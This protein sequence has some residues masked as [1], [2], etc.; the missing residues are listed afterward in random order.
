MRPAPRAC[1]LQSSHEKREY[2][3]FFPWSFPRLAQSRESSPASRDFSISEKSGPNI[4]AK[5]LRNAGAGHA[6]G[7]LLYRKYLQTCVFGRTRYGV[8]VA[9]AATIQASASA[10]HRHAQAF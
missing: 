5:N 9:G 6:V 8:H 3:S 7:T 2:I 4:R 1:C 10:A